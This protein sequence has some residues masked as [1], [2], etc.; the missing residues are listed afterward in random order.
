M[1]PHLRPRTPPCWVHEGASTEPEPAAEQRGDDIV[2]PMVTIITMLIMV[3]IIT[4]LIMVTRF[5]V[6]A[7]RGDCSPR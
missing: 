3:T 4:M 1:V 2:I 5:A 6:G 7:S